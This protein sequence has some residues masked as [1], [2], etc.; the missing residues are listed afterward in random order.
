MTNSILMRV[1]SIF[2]SKNVKNAGWI[3]AEQVFQMLVSLVIG[4]L[5]ARYLGPSNYGALNYT[6]SFIAFFTSIATLGME[7]VIIKKFI[8]N[9]EQEGLYLGSCI[10]FRL[11]SSFLSSIAILL[12]VFILNIDDQV[13]LM[14][15]ALQTLQLLFRA[16]AIF[17]SWFQRHL[18]SKYVSIA[19]MIAYVIV[20]AYKIFLLAT[21]KSIRWFAFSNSFDYFLIAIALYVFY[22]REKGQPLRFSFKIGKEVLSESYHFIISGIMVAVFGQMDKIMIGKMMTDA[23]VGFYT[24]AAGICTMWIFV[25]QAIINSFRPTI[26][27]LKEKGQEGLYKQRLEQ[28]YSVIIYLCL[29]VSAVIALLAPYIIRILFGEAYLGAIGPLV[30]LIWSEV[31]SMIGTARGIWILSENKNKYVKY[32]LFWGAAANLILNALLIPL[33]GIN[34][35]AFAT[36]V[37]QIVTSLIAP[38]FYRETRIHTKIVMEA[39]LLKWY[40]KRR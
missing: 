11:V 20:S 25:P 37:T 1:K 16:F 21:S 15:A 17:D 33:C 12:L 38:M 32:Y 14:L 29:V 31:F 40:K 22:K 34:G 3:V 35:A 4:V 39:V 6:A 2:L 28:L 19:K 27:E 36:L 23:D 24:T 7:G 13:K 18:K 10:V 5:S 30:I 26:M 8:S 9:P